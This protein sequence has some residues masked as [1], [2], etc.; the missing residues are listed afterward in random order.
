MD[1]TG[2]SEAMARHFSDTNGRSTLP[3]SLLVSVITRYTPSTSWASRL[4][5]PSAQRCSLRWSH[6]PPITPSSRA[7]SRSRPASAHLWLSARPQL[8]V[9][10]CLKCATRT[11]SRAHSTR[12]GLPPIAITPF[13]TL[14]VVCSHWCKVKSL[15][16]VTESQ[17]VDDVDIPHFDVSPVIRLVLSTGDFAEGSS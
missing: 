15:M 6:I 8:R 1:S 10:M 14:I 9:R 2:N 5:E 4:I 3:T 13:G 17:S 11:R 12:A 7:Q 16:E